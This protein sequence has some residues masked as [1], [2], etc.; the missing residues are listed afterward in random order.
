MTDLQPFLLSF[1]ILLICL[2]DVSCVQANNKF[3]HRVVALKYSVILKART[4][5]F[6]SCVHLA[7]LHA[8]T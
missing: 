3:A 7:S 5:G 6:L 8:V 2:G 4:N 1:A